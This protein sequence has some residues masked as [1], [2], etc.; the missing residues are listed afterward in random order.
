MTEPTDLALLS[1][2]DL[3]AKFREKK[4]SP[5]EAA[6]AALARAHRFQESLNPFVLID[7]DSAMADARTSEARWQKGEPAGPADGVPTTIKDLVYTRGW[8]TLRGS[9]AVP[10][11]QPW[12]DDAPVTAHLRASGAVLLGKTTTPEMG[13][14]GVTDS[15]L[16]GITRNPWNPDKTPGGSSGGAAAATAVGAGAL[17]IGTDGGGSIRIP[18][19]FTGI[20]GHKATFGRVPAWPLS[21]FGTIANVGPMT[22]TVSDAALMLNVIARPDWRDWYNYAGDRNDYLA[23]LD[24]GVAGLRVAFSPTLGGNPVQP[25]VAEKVAAAARTLA[26][27]GATVEEAEPEL[28]RDHVS[29]VFIA[30]W[31]TVANTVVNGFDMEAKSAM[32][33]GLL[34]IALVGSEYSTQNLIR[35]ETARREIGFQIN[36]FFQDYDLLLTPSLPITAFDVGLVAPPADEEGRTWINWTPFSYPF[37]LSRNPA[38][39]VP[40]GL[41]DGLPVGLQIVG[42]HYED[43][44]VLRAARAFEAAQPWE[45]P[46]IATA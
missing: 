14:K 30:H 16:T 35:A 5:V 6:E 21:P 29:G 17:A 32:D 1:A 22:R 42:R 46:P 43:N 3:V 39:S 15:P 13:W 20:F 18:A 10:A 37:N 2:T 19:G 25:G 40:C 9:K 36:K 4:A 31:F 7:D 45:L 24:D 8:P 38:C 26:D 44:T 27:L 28:D 11:D 41:V 33:P 34:H 12:D 23:G